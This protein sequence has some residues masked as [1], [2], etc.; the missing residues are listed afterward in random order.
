MKG[1]FHV[2]F[3]G[4]CGRGNPSALTRLIFFPAAVLSSAFRQQPALRL[5]SARL[6]YEVEAIQISAFLLNSR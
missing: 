1:N 4:E 6:D 2:R 3:L 5:L